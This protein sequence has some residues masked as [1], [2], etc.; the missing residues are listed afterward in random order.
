MLLLWLY[1]MKTCFGWKFHASDSDIAR[2]LCEQR[3]P[4]ANSLPVNFAS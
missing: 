3:H 2:K 1:R 4:A